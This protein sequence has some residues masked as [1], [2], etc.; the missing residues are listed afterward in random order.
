V[1]GWRRQAVRPPILVLDTTLSSPVWPTAAVLQALAV[2]TGAPLVIEVRSGLK[3]DQQGLEV[4]NLG[5]VGIYQHDVPLHPGLSAE[6]VA[7][8]L[9]L[10][11]AISGGGLPVAASAA[12]DVPFLLDER[13]TRLHSGQLF[14]NNARLAE[15]LAAVT[16]GLFSTV[17]HPV[18]DGGG[19]APF[20]VVELPDDDLADYGLL[21]AV[22][23]HEVDR[24]GLIA[25]HGSSFGFRTTRFE[26][27]IPNRSRGQALFKIA[28]G[29]R[30][31]P[32]LEA[33]AQL[34]A[35]IGGYRSMRELAADCDLPPVRLS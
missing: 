31:G 17:A 32:S 33:F 25:I 24:R 35:E 21:L 27:I 10:A 6:R 18:L 26:T 4:S 12:L 13:W 14:R 11:R 15:R 29:A 1:N 28:A 16:G 19:H 5:I 20:V 23:R 9:A 3:L 30:T 22:L 7:E 34:M 2:P 8:T